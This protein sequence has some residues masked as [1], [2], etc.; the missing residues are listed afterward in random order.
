MPWASAN[1]LAGGYK[2]GGIGG[3]RLG[4]P[5]RAMRRRRGAGWLRS[6]P[7]G[8]EERTGGLGARFA[9]FSPSGLTAPRQVLLR[10]EAEFYPT[11]SVRRKKSSDDKDFLLHLGSDTGRYVN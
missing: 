9:L 2:A 1:E 4:K 5:P 3:A 6:P 10:Y 8:E 11:R 7:T